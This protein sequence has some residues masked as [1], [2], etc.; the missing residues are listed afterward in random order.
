MNEYVNEVISYLEKIQD[1]PND[2]IASPEKSGW[3]SSFEGVSNTK[4]LDASPEWKLEASTPA[5]W[6]KKVDLKAKVYD[7]PKVFLLRSFHML[8]KEVFDCKTMI[9]QMKVEVDYSKNKEN[10]L[11]YLFFMMHQRGFPVNEIYEEKL[12]NVPTSRFM[13]YVQ[14]LEEDEAK[15]KQLPVDD[16]GEPI[17]PSDL[18]FDSQ[19]QVPS[20]YEGPM[21]QPIRPECV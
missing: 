18:S 1:F 9:E 7:S 2:K 6:E 16:N 5:T 11:M 8:V 17:P 20:L 4:S 10:K 21:P 12:K 15:M 19:S 13:D 14:Q 3:K